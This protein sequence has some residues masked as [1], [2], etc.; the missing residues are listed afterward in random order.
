[1]VAWARARREGCG[2][3]PPRPQAGTQA[4]LKHAGERFTT[5]EDRLGELQALLR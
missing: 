5:T 1:M 2:S 3:W 4:P